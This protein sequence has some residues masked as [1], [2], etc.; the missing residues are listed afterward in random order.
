MLPSERWQT[1]GSGRS[2]RRR[3][4][5]T[6]RIS[7]SSP[8]SPRFEQLLREMEP[9]D[10]GPETA[11]RADEYLRLLYA[12]YHF[13]DTGRSDRDVRREVL[14]AEGAR[15][16]PGPQPLPLAGA[17]YCRFPERWFWGQVADGLP[18]EPLD[19]LF[20]VPGGRGKREWIVVAVL[21]V[22]ADR[23]GFSQISVTASAN[24]IAA[25][26]SLRDPPFAPVMSGGDLA[27]V[28]LDHIRRGI[29]APRS[30]RAAFRRTVASRHSWT[31]KT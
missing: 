18:H 21:G 7:G 27:G 8:G 3:T 16:T 12:G 19:G 4:G 17:V 20:V 6:R 26:T 15:T 10:A 31:G 13:W 28:S 23:G 29:A 14:E 24:D 1:N 2:V 9:G 5:S 25:A 30:P 22:R 11:E